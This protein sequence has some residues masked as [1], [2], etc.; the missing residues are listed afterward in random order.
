MKKENS[1]KIKVKQTLTVYYKDEEYKTI[2]QIVLK[3]IEKE[4][5]G[6]K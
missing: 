5:G 3:L 1:D 2:E 6:R 4:I